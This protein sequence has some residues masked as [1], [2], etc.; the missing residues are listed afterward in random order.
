MASQPLVR[1]QWQAAVD[2]QP[3]YSAGGSLLIHY[4]SPAITAKNTVIVP[5]KTGAT[6][7]F[8]LNAH[9]GA[10]GTLLWSMTSDYILPPHRWIPSYGTTATLQSAVFYGVSVYNA[11]KAACDA[12]IFIHTP[13]TADAQ[14]NIFFGFMATA[15]NPGGVVSGLARVA[16][17]G[18]SSPRWRRPNP[19]RRMVWRS[20]DE[21]S[22][23]P[24]GPHGRPRLPRRRHGMVHQ[25]R[26][27][28]SHHQIYAD[29]HLPLRHDPYWCAARLAAAPRTES[30][31]MPS[32]LRGWA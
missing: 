15:G 21:G 11:A 8:K 25:Y 5:V 28:G 22:A 9:L 29:S 17:D 4:G 24:A 20:R 32:C 26:G 1:I 19:D 30:R 31:W 13:L 27:R 7:S 16:A 12:S 2:L 18:T 14:G 3:Q 10:T 6:D 23:N